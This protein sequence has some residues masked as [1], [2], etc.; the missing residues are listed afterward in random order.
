MGSYDFRD[1]HNDRRSPWSPADRDLRLGAAVQRFD[2]RIR[3]AAGGRHAG[4][5]E[6]LEV[7][8]RFLCQVWAEEVLEEQLHLPP[9]AS[10]PLVRL[11]TMGTT[12]VRSAPPRPCLF[13]RCGRRYSR[14]KYAPTVMVRKP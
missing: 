2:Q 6:R 8:C 3:L 9:S 13:S 11:V 14:A 12:G 4:F 1:G 7:S 10:S 5:G